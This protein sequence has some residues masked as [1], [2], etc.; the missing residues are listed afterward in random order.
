MTVNIQ[1]TFKRDQ[2]HMDGLGAIAEELAKNPLQARIIVATV[3]CTRVTHNVKDGTDV[4]T[5]RLTAVEVCEGTDAVTVST[6]MERLYAGRTGRD[7]LPQSLFDPP[8]PDDEEQPNVEAD[9][10]AEAWP[11]DVDFTA[12]EFGETPDPADVQQLDV[13]PA[14]EPEAN[15]GEQP[16]DEA[17]PP[18]PKR[19]RRR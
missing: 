3:E 6:I 8:Q 14:D 9:R 7:D 2:S 18:Q 12:P 10:P 11:G 16:D 13:P 5:V 19:G 17:D 15:T 4:P 1:A